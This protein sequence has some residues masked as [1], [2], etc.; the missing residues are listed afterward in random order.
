MAFFLRRPKLTFSADLLTTSSLF[1]RFEADRSTSV[2]ILY[3]ANKKQKALDDQSYITRLVND[4]L[5]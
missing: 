3:F 4:S 2:S 5:F 1:S